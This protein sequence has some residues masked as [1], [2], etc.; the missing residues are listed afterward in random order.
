MW[1]G[2]FELVVPF[3]EL[4]HAFNVFLGNAHVFTNGRVLKE[5]PYVLMAGDA[6]YP[7]MI[8]LASKVGMIS[9]AF[10]DIYHKPYGV[11]SIPPFY[12]FLSFPLTLSLVL[13]GIITDKTGHISLDSMAFVT[14]LL[15]TDQI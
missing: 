15:I 2:R 8:M 11:Q 14:A 9:D 3:P 13:V 5:I 6:E 7:L 12:A 1:F 4:T 10:Y